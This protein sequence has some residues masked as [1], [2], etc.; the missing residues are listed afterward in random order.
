M[1]KSPVEDESEE[2]A[3]NESNNN[4][5]CE[6]E[7]TKEDHQELQNDLSKMFVRP[8]EEL[9][10]NKK[11]HVFGYDKSNNFHILDSSKPVQF[12]SAGFLEEVKNLTNKCQHCHRVGHLETVL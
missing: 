8:W 2:V 4:N 6:F 12:V 9:S 3:H 1:K 10:F 11:R 7:D 5:K